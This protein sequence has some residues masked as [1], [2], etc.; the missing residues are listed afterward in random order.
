MNEC[1][2]HL[3]MSIH[4]PNSAFLKM[5]AHCISSLSEVAAEQ[6]DGLIRDGH[7]M[8]SH[9]FLLAMEQHACLTEASGWH[10][11]YLLLEQSQ[12]LV[13]AMPLF[14][15]HNSWGEF[16]FDQA[17]AEAYARYGE[18]YYPKLVAAIPFSPVFGQKLLIEAGREKELYPQLMEAALQVA[19]QLQ[20]SS[21]HILF[22]LPE[23]QQYFEQ[24]G[25]IAR[26]DCQYHWENQNYASFDEF[27]GKLI[28]KKRKN[29]RQ[30]RRKV[31]E[32]GI[33]FRQ[34][35][36]N[37]ASTEDWRQFTVFYDSTYERKWGAPIFNQ[38]FFE[39]VAG[40]LGERM[41]LVLA[42][43]EG[44]AI[45]GA[46]M[47]RSDNILYGRHWGCVE[48][49][50]GLHFETCYYRGIEY[51]IEHGIRIF[52][53]GAQGE[54]KIARGFAPV[55][56]HSAHW[57]QDERFRPAVEQFCSEERRA[58]AQYIEQAQRHSPYKQSL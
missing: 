20:V 22:P 53:P 9:G 12:R 27:L 40:A 57:L 37:T 3:A 5:K 31:A 19:R 55:R 13:A 49:H 11:R 48:Y 30:Q 15:K 42:E 18:A 7:P 14:E 29:I 24:Q 10:P 45:A 8:L 38:A 39:A 4:E 46:L 17:W 43:R 47:Y 54:H 41:I 52:E 33:R 32:A 21:V 6:W 23:E 58:V 35:D 2:F 44:V 16:V 28:H 26:H 56:T 36:G 34:L 50:D 25:W 51:C 1:Y